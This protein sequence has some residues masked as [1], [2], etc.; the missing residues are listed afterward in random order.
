MTRVIYKYE[1]PLKD[2]TVL[3]LPHIHWPLSV[4]LDAEG[5]L[6]MWAE[7]ET[8]QSP[9]D[10]AYRKVKVVGTGHAGVP[11][12]TEYYFLGTVLQTP[13]VWHIYLEILE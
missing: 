11:D 9:S 6:C 3:T 1:I 7:V 13:Y 10:L 8:D 12:D 5:H 4:G 2:E